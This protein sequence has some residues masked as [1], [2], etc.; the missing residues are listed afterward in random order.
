MC[1]V[2]QPRLHE[3]ALEEA[4]SLRRC[5]QIGI[6]GDKEWGVG[7][8]CAAALQSDYQRAERTEAGACF[9]IERVEGTAGCPIAGCRSRP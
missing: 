3:H 5:D 6:I 2:A 8:V 1:N 7:R 9:V 4:L